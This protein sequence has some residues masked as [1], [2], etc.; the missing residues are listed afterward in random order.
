MAL[1]TSKSMAVDSREALYDSASSPSG[2]FASSDGPDNPASRY[3]RFRKVLRTSATKSHCSSNDM[4]S[5]VPSAR[6]RWCSGATSRTASSDGASLAAV[7]AP[8]AS[9]PGKQALNTTQVTPPQGPRGDIAIHPG[10][11]RCSADLIAGGRGPVRWRQQRRTPLH[12][13]GMA[14]IWT[15]RDGSLK[16]VLPQNGRL[17][18]GTGRPYR[19]PCSTRP[20]WARCH[21]AYPDNLRTAAVGNDLGRFIKGDELTRCVL[22]PHTSNKAVVP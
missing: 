10:M 9:R 19:T 15:R 17:R 11:S 5:S 3:L 6:R 14:V 8:S 2:C 1:V 4:E 18:Q 16:R 7:F 21:A 12:T 20:T 13:A 22:R